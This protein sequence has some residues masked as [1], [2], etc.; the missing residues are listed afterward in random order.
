M[1][2]VENILGF[3]TPHDHV[4]NLRPGEVIPEG[5]DAG[6]D[7]LGALD[8]RWIWVFESGAEIK[9]V[10]VASDCHGCAFIWRL[11]ISPGMPEFSVVKLLRRFLKDIRMR[12]MKGYLTIADRS[13]ETQDRLANVIIHAGGKQFGTYSLFAS[14]MPKEGI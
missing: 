14:P 9:G 3:L 1:S 5:L 4:R 13:S 2:A 12:G 10:L 7:L 6:F 11:A 8:H